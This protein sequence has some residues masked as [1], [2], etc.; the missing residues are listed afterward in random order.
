MST[1][2]LLL[3]LICCVGLTGC[4]GSRQPSA[5]QA[6]VS[7]PHPYNPGTILGSVQGDQLVALDVPV[8]PSEMMYCRW[9]PDGQRLVYGSQGDLWLW[10]RNTGQSVNLTNTPDRWELMPAWSPDG[11]MLCFTS[12]PLE[13][14][15]K[16]RRTP[17]GYWIMFGGS[18]G[19]PTI[20]RADGTGYEVL[21]EGTVANPT[22]APDGQTVA[23]GSGDNIHLYD[24]KSH[25]VN[26]LTPGDV[27]LQ[28]KYIG[29]PS[30]SP[31]GSELAFFFACSDQ[32]PTRQE[33]IAKTAAKVTQGYALLN[34]KTNKVRVLY[35]WPGLFKSYRNPALWNSDG[36]KLAL[37]LS[38][39]PPEDN[40]DD[41]LV[42]DHD[43]GR[44]Q[45]IVDRAYQAVWSP[46][47]QQLA[48]IDGD[49]SLIVNLVSFNGDT[50]T[51]RRISER[52]YTVG[53]LTWPPQAN[54]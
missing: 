12:R 18:V 15:E 37:N 13:P 27:G 17:D 4:A 46:D 20:I 25:Q 26:V 2:A 16:S 35:T 47:G 31:D 24:L 10:N 51:T 9:S 1:L 32:E 54:R 40:H 34:L 53:G 43:S 21:E 29:V 49:S 33:V 42:I 5:N 41:L 36:S 6:P 23:Y 14:E 28:A 45:A 50:Y 22:W 8:D 48:Y 11:T 38:V 44:A 19:S 3:T 52:A 7:Q 30:W 39:G